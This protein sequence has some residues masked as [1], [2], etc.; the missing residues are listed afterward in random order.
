M[1]AVVV[2]VEPLVGSVDCG[3]HRE[4]SIG[5][6]SLWSVRAPVLHRHIYDW[7]QKTAAC[8]HPRALVNTDGKS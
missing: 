4:Q 8:M 2:A 7:L 6:Q 1:A 5:W 3:T